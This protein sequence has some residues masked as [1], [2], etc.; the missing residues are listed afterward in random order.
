MVSACV[1]P[2]KLFHWCIL[3]K[4]VIILAALLWCRLI[5]RLGRCVPR[6][7]RLHHTA[8]IVLCHIRSRIHRHQLYTSLYSRLSAAAGDLHPRKYHSA[9]RDSFYDCSHSGKPKI[10]VVGTWI[11]FKKNFLVNKEQNQIC[12]QNAPTT[13]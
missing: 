5:Q 4:R 12:P 10:F 7:E 8:R 3:I 1:A 2:L 13:T 6:H 11:S 9:S